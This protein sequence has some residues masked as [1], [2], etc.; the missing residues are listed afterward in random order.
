V[1][2]PARPSAGLLAA[3]TPVTPISLTQ[4]RSLLEKDL[5]ARSTPEAYRAAYREVTTALGKV[6]LP[7]VMVPAPRTWWRMMAGEA[8]QRMALDSERRGTSR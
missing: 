7:A 6:E 8:V 5:T 3:R 1:V 4:L 2:F